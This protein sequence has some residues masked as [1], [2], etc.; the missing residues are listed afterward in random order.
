MSEEFNFDRYSGNEIYFH[1]QIYTNRNKPE[2]TKKIQCAN[3]EKL[4]RTYFLYVNLNKVNR[5]VKKYDPNLPLKHNVMYVEALDEFQSSLILGEED[6]LAP[7]NKKKVALL[8]EILFR[9][10]KKERRQTFMKLKVQ[11]NGCTVVVQIKVNQNAQSNFGTFSISE[12]RQKFPW[13]IQKLIWVARCYNK[14]NFGMLSKSLVDRILNIYCNML[15]YHYQIN[16][17]KQMLPKQLS[18][19]PFQK[20]FGYESPY[21]PQ[22]ASIPVARCNH[23]SDLMNILNPP[24]YESDEDASYDSTWIYKKRKL[25]NDP[26]NKLNQLISAIFEENR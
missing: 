2:N 4:R 25:N 11:C 26:E 24:G 18:F 17:K 14:E 10:T 22:M 1:C 8:N 5:V 6:T 13:E 3:N 15:P 12:I 23:P 7:K 21:I 20:P 16:D 9:I 19:E